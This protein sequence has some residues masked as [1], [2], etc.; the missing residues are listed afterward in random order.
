MVVDVGVAV[1]DGYLCLGV[2]LNDALHTLEV[3]P[4]GEGAAFSS[5]RALV[6]RADVAG[7]LD[8]RTQCTHA[9]LD[10]LLGALDGK[11]LPDL[12]TFVYSLDDLELY[13]D[14]LVAFI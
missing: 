14:I 7:T 4:V 12:L 6:A 1:L 13:V 5:C 3:R 10:C 2:H 9:D 8:D 11:V